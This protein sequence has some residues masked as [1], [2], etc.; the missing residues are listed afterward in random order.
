M[1]ELVAASV[2]AVFATYF[3]MIVR[4]LFRDLN[5]MEHRHRP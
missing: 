3:Y 4:G 2:A 1:F 5:E